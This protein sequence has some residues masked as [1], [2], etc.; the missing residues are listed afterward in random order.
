MDNAHNC[1]SYMHRVAYPCCLKSHTAWD[2]AAD[3]LPSN[4]FLYGFVIATAANSML[5]I[6]SLLS[7]C[8]IT[9]TRQGK[10]V[11]KLKC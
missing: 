2:Q 7:Q 3:E 9:V 5:N 6:P 11:V 8:I 10:E 4:Q 1:E